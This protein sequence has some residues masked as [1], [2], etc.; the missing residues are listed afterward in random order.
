[1]CLLAFGIFK[2]T[3]YEIS[4]IDLNNTPV[5]V[6]CSNVMGYGSEEFS[7]RS[8]YEK[9]I[10]VCGMPKPVKNDWLEIFIN[11]KLHKI[12]NGS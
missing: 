9:A 8:E 6:T 1:M 2:Y 7:N 10:F 5:Y 4:K 11:K 3:I 12:I